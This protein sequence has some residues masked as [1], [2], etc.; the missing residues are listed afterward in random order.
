MSKGPNRW[1][2][3]S[4]LLL[5]TAIPSAV[6]GQGADEYDVKAAFL[7]NF[8]KFIEWPQAANAAFAICILG[9]DPFGTT[10][11]RL[12]NGKTALGKPFQVRRI[13]EPADAKQCQLAFISS[14][15]KS[16]EP[17]LVEAVGESAVLTV[18]ET[19][20]F[21]NKGGMIFLSME[22]SNVSIVIN[23]TATDKARLKISAKLMTLAKVF[24]GGGK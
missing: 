16:K 13:K 19:K 9:D 6:S 2:G 4:C 5:L 24:K 12:V 21:L 15:E 18:G 10:I 3:W 23:T 8:T 20:D 17:K 14:I 1:I 11:D 7:Y 22:E